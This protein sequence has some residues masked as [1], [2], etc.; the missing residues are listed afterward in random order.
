MVFAL[1]DC[2]NFFVSCERLFQPSLNGKPVV[3]LSNN[4]GCVIAR[5]NEAKALG[6]KMAQP[7][8]QVADLVEKS[9]LNVF[10][11]N[12]ALY[13]DLSQRVMSILRSL[14]PKTEVYSID[15]AFM[16]VGEIENLSEF[17]HNVVKT[18]KRQ[19]GIP[20]S[21]G[22]AP[23]KTLAKIASKLCKQYPKLDGCCVMTRQQDIEKVLKKFPIN[24]VWGIGRRY[25]KM[26][27]EY[28]VNTAWDFTQLSPEFVKRKMSVVGLRTQQELKGISSI[29]IETALPDK[30]SICVSRSFAKELTQYEDLHASLMTFIA[31]AAEKLRKQKSVASQVSV[32]IFTN[33]FRDDTK[34]HFE[35]K[36]IK[37]EAST[38]STLQ[39]AHHVSQ[40][41]RS[42]YLEGYGYKK[43]GVIL[44][45][46]SSAN[47]VQQSIFE[48]GKRAKHSQLMSAVDE[49]NRKQGRNSVVLAA[50]G[51]DPIKMN[52]QHLSPSYTTDWNDI[53]KVKV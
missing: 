44:S 7:F 9:G 47:G 36:V 46:I 12:F 35:N 43:A 21:V 48:N 28:G 18:V 11:S 33:R 53:L 34:Q 26:L 3:V 24:D 1:C 49:L 41:L 16:E 39:L 45:D 22:I 6:I 20:V 52:R 17:G 40:A 50:Q 10:S 38:D 29:S 19:V 13:G 5:S 2:N 23:T 42:I 25:A 32:F 31:M 4:D 51:F 14:S 8:F 30:Q 37:F 27:S 15:E